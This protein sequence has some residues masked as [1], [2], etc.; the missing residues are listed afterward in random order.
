MK[1]INKRNRVELFKN[2]NETSTLN[3]FKNKLKMK[4]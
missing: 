4:F 3:I 1:I 2:V